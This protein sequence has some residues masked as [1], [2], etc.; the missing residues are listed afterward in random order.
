[1]WANS[2]KYTL[3]YFVEDTLYERLRFG[4]GRM[5]TCN[6][7]TRVCKNLKNAICEEHDNLCMCP[8][9]TVAYNSECIEMWGRLT[10]DA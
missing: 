1:M 10:L 2:E 7:K 9:N 4:N 3:V 5:E 6:M 8:L